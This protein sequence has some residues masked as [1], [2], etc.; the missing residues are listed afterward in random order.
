MGADPEIEQAKE[1]LEWLRGKLGSRAVHQLHPEG[2]FEGKKGTF[3]KATVLR[4]RLLL[5]MQHGYIAAVKK[6]QEGQ[7]GRLSEVSVL[8]PELLETWDR[9]RARDDAG[10]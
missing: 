10:G 4:E 8:R 7:P 2:V 6:R 5:L 3:K 1:L 9:R